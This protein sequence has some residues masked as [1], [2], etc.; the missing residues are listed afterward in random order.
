MDKEKL[1]LV[2]FGI[3]SAVILAV[4]VSLIVRHETVI[5][6]GRE[7]RFRTRPVDPFDAFRGRFVA[8]SLQETS[9]MNPAGLTVKQGQRVCALIEVDPDGFARFSEVTFRPHPDDVYLKCRV[10]GVSGGR[11]NLDVPLDRYYMEENKAP[12]AERLYSMRSRRSIS[13]AYVVVAVR[14]G[15][16]VIKKLYVAGKPIEEA[17]KDPQALLADPGWQ[18]PV[19]RRSAPRPPAPQ[20]PVTQ[21]LQQPDSALP[22]LAR[23]TMIYPSGADVGSCRDSAGKMYPATGPGAARWFHWG[24]CSSYKDYDVVPGQQ[25]ILY[26][27]GDDCSSCVCFRADFTVYEQRRDEWVATQRFDLPEIPGLHIPVYY[28]PS[29]RTIRII[30]DAC[31]YLDVYGT[32]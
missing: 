7:F 24:G 8:L 30:A 3:F 27:Y 11:V 18:S 15:N 26:A 29:S 32:K 10:S 12:A 17:L 2:L 22:D 20:V 28:T 5:Q 13:D 21:V 16:G 1:R 19:Q 14:Q 6:Q 23:W 4:P 9:A 25:I 31:F